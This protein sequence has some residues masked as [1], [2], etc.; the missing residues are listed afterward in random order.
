MTGVFTY[1]SLMFPRSGRGSSR[2]AIDRSP[3]ARR[4]RT[5][6]G[7]RRDYPGMVAPAGGRSTAWCTSMSTPP[8]SHGSTASKA[9]TTGAKPSRSPAP[10]A[11]RD[12]RDL[13]LSAARA[14]HEKPVGPGGV[15]DRRFVATYCRDHLAPCVPG[16]I[17]DR[18]LRRRRDRRRRGRHDV[19]GRRG[20]ARPRVVLIDHAAKLAEK[21]RIS[22]GGRCNFTNRHVGPE[23]FLSRNPHFAAAALA[24]Y[25]PQDFIAL[26][27]RTASAS[28]RSIGAS[29]SATSRAN[30]SSPCWWPSAT[31]ARQWRGRSARRSRRG[32][33]AYAS[34]PTTD[35]SSPTRRRRDRR[36][37]DPQDRRHGFR[38]PHRAQFG[39]KIVE[40]RPA[41]VPLTFAPTL[42]RRSARWPASRSRSTWLRRRRS[43]RFREDLLFTHRGLSG[44]AI[45]QISTYWRPGAALEIDL[46]PA[47]TSAPA[48]S[49]ENGRRARSCRTCSPTRPAPPRRPVARDAGSSTADRRMPDARW[50]HW[51]R[52]QSLAHHARRHRRLPQ[53]RGHARRRRHR[54]LSQ[55]TLEAQRVPGLHFVGEA[56]DV[57]GWLGGYNFQWAWASGVA[58]GVS[59]LAHPGRPLV[60]PS[61]ET[62]LFSR[63]SLCATGHRPTCFPFQCRPFASKKTSRSKSP[64]VASSAP[65]KRPAC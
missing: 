45:L 6:R 47:S 36:P 48:S 59:G 18:P 58:A 34:R 1:G 53:G 42:G 25:T 7:R 50:A 8:M 57:T 43:A 55:Q 51:P 23:N 65:S 33:T 32:A 49:S 64:C 39:L 61:H 19:R 52:S 11:R 41:L 60:F 35:G 28:T 29:C 62:T 16:P 14:A 21:I 31:R 22:G 3:A 24:R 38:L 20:A 30:R 13:R 46:V 4:P 40:P 54:E 15:P 5:V 44:P 37:V 17:D 63:A 9:T 10:R 56:V 12:R 27:E 26:V 2:V